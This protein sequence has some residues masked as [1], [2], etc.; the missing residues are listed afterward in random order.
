MR[1][2]KITV[3][4]MAALL[5]LTARAE[6]KATEADAKKVGAELVEIAKAKGIA[7]VVD[8]V[9]NSDVC[10]SY[11]DRGL[12]CAIHDA[13]LKILANPLRPALVGQVMKDMMDP[14]GKNISAALLGPLK[15]DPKQTHWEAEFKFSA[16]GSKVISLRKA[17][18]YRLDASHAACVTVIKG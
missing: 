18:C 10:L 17:N 11:K 12:V 16:P 13:D 5:A 15:S 14:D 2:P 9:N 6:D 1:H 8:A 7:A 3:A 4:V